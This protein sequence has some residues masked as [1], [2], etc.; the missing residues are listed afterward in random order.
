MLLLVLLVEYLGDIFVTYLLL[1]LLGGAY[2]GQQAGVYLHLEVF[3]DAPFVEGV[4][5]L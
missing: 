4:R 2:Q 3:L 5:A 1:A